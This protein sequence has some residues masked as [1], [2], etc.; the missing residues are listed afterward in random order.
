MSRD[1]QMKLLA[2]LADREERRAARS[3]SVSRRA[4]SEREAVLGNLKSYR[5]EYRS[6]FADP[7]IDADTTAGTLKSYRAF[8]D[9]LDEG[10]AQAESKVDEASRDCRRQESEWRARRAR[11]LALERLLE[12][13]AAATRRRRNRGE[14]RLLDEHTNRQ[15]GVDRERDRDR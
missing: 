10:I 7:G 3:V 13:Q 4:L 15:R 12:R 6:R 14:Q 5:R 9:Q 8:L 1:G 2:G 11:A